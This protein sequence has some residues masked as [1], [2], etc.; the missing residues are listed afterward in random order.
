MGNIKSS[1]GAYLCGNCDIM[2]LALH[3]LTG[4][5]M[6]LWSG[7]YVDPDADDGI[8]YEHAHA[9]IMLP[10]GQ[11]MDVNGVSANTPDNLYFNMPVKEVV[12]LP[13]SE[14]D[15]RDAFTC[16]DIEDDAIQVAIDFVL[17]YPPLAEAVSQLRESANMAPVPC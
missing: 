6:G 4:K 7:K 3:K 14:L 11:W 15:V 12:L 8:G 10:D 1:V 2:A 5:P 17:S 16:C 13:A 9:C